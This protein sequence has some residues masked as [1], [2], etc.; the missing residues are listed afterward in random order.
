[1]KPSLGP[2]WELCLRQGRAYIDRQVDAQP[3]CAL[4]A[5]E[6][7]VL[8]LMDGTRTLDALSELLTCALGETGPQIL[9]TLLTRVRPLLVDGPRRACPYSLEC[10]SQVAP[11]DPQEGLRPLPGPRVLHWWVTSYCPRRCVYCFARPI[12]GG[13]AVDAILTRE[14]LQRIFA[15]AASLGAEAL[16]V[17]GAEP[18]LRDD[19][20]E[21]LGDA[22]AQGI[23]PLLTTKH[24]I[25]LSLAQR[26]AQAGVRHLSLSVDTMDE[27]ENRTLIGSAT[28]SLQV[29]RSVQHLTRAG[30]AFS[31]QAVATRL[32]PQSLHGVAAFAAEAGA[33]MLQ[34]VPFEPVASPISQVSNHDML[35]EHL[36]PLE[37][38]VTLLARQ[39]PELR[40]ELFEK[41]GSGSRSDLHCDIGM[42][43]LF[44]LPNGVV[45][46]CYKLTHDDRLQGSDLRKVS[47]AAAWHDPGF[48]TII[49]PPREH[50]AG[51][52][53][54]GCGR[55]SACHQEGR[56]IYQAWVSHARY[57]ARDRH[58]DGPYLT[59][60]PV[61]AQ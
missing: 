31:I 10:L 30:I 58:C 34:V 15:E 20:P 59:S 48:R 50:Y 13:R 51:A 14:A 36:V 40:M 25:T 54:Y 32:N 7:V 44:F 27:H 26:F 33:Q 2:A 12:F 3:V 4:S 9:H 23:L 21:V 61:L 42:T 43:K 49:S 35:L 53:C 47:V 55:F 52:D 41:L 22:V 11:P 6:A 17:A 24:P 60:L 8:G 19:L 29:R 39:F 38:Q 1:M 45:H 56:C 46:R 57:E 5:A 16:L 37:E 18:L 28:Y